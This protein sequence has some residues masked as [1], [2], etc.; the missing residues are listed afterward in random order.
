MTDTV[1]GVEDSGRDV[2]GVGGGMLV[3]QVVAVSLTTWQSGL[4]KA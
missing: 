2:V 3:G 1:V 4:Q